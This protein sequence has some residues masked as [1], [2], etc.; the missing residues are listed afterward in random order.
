MLVVDLL[1]YIINGYRSERRSSRG[2]L[3]SEFDVRVADRDMRQ[4][5]APRI[6]VFQPAGG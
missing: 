4:K 1:H 6:R 3:Q 5:L 2:D